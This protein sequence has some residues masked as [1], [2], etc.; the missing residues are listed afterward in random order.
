MLLFVVVFVV[1]LVVVVAVV[2][3]DVVVKRTSRGL[4]LSPTFNQLIYLQ[5]I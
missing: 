1:V 5:I 3:L 2:V 4:V